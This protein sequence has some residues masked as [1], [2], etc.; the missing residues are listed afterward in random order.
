MANFVNTHSNPVR[1]AAGVF[2]D[3]RVHAATAGVLALPWRNEP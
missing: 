3:M 2:D 1:P